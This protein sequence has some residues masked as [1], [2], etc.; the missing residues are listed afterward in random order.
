MTNSIA[1]IKDASVLLVIGSNTTEAHPVIA[2]QMKAA[3]RKHGAKLILIDPRRIELAQFAHLHLRQIPGSDVALIN[4]MAHVILAEGLEN[5]TFIAERTEGLDAFRKVVQE[6]TPE[7]AAAV[8]GVPPELIVQAA[9]LYAGAKSAAIFWA[10]GITQHTTGTDNV[11]ALSNLALLCGQVGRPGTGLNPLRGQNNV[12]G[13]CDMGGLPNVMTGYQTVVDEGVRRKFADGWGAPLERLSSKVGLTVTEMTEGALQGKVHAIFI[14]GENPMLTD[15]NLHHVEEALRKVDFL[16]VQD[17]FPNETGQFADVVLA[18]ASF[19]EKEGTFTNTER[20]VQR[21]RTALPPPGE[22]REDWRILTDLAQRMGASWSYAGA[23]DVFDEMA[24]LTPS[25]GGMS[26][27]RL[28]AGGLQW[29][30]P[31]PDHPGTPIL[32]TQ[33]F[34]RGVG[35]FAP[36]EYRPPAEQPDAEFPL[37]LTTG[38]VLFHWHGGTLSRRS[39]GLDSLAPAAEVEIHPED[40]RRYHVKANEPIRVRSRRG[41]VVASARLTRRSLPGTIFMTFHY[42]EAAVNLLTGGA[43][44]PIAKIPEYKVTAV[45]LEP[46]K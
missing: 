13:A 11:K 2:L 8:S 20:C 40:A 46:V 15:P 35:Q 3:V 14:L 21:V 25:Y 27:A 41:Q 1:D 22:A 42:A 28:E 30:C 38:R 12:Q 4:G 6:W 17:I 39:P 5:K 36:I 37:V 34:S 10:M 31:A 9:R 29:P 7:R 24:C 33:K 16:A 26:H 43:V 45:R 18:G 23:A 44:D 32:H 19:A